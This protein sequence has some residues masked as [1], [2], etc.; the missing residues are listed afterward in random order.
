MS[1]VWSASADIDLTG[2]DVTPIRADIESDTIRAHLGPEYG[3]MIDGKVSKVESPETF[4]SG[5]YEGT[6]TAY[7]HVVR[8]QLTSEPTFYVCRD[9][10][11]TAKVIDGKYIRPQPR[12]SDRE[13]ASYAKN[14]EVD[15]FIARLKEYRTVKVTSTTPPTEF[16]KV[17]LGPTLVGPSGRV[18]RPTQVETKR[19]VD[20]SKSRV[21]WVYQEIMAEACEPWLEA[22][23]QQNPDGIESTDPNVPP[24]IEP[25]YPGWPS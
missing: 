2:V 21:E 7:M 6:G 1:F 20:V 19:R 15:V 5:F 12:T 9:L 3:Y 17:P 8:A 11:H 10:T 25:F 4:D 18:A 22:R 24:K 16:G 14:A 13:L 23:R